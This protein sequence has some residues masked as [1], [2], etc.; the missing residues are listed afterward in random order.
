MCFVISLTSRSIEQTKHFLLFYEG[1]FCDAVYTKFR[2][3]DDR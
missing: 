2:R 3:Y 1:I